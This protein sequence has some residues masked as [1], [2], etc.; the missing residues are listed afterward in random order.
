MDAEI[1]CFDREPAFICFSVFCK[2]APHFFLN[3]F[4]I[5]CSESKIFL[6]LNQDFMQ[7]EIYSPIFLRIH[8]EFSC[9]KAAASLF[10]KIA[11]LSGNRCTTDNSDSW[12]GLNRSQK[13]L[14]DLQYAKAGRSRRESQAS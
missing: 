4:I 3:L 9:S 14:A 7:N 1:F 10:H 13:P 8:I 2:I 6:E 11:D 5:L 12:R